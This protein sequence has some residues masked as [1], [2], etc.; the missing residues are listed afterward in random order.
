MTVQTIYDHFA[1]TIAAMNPSKVLEIH[2]PQAASERLESL[3]EKKNEQ[4]LSAAE[5]D[6]LDHF[7]VLERLVRLA[8]AHARLQLAGL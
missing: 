8:K 3:I 7:L 4:G 1:E 6:E 2:A 5:K